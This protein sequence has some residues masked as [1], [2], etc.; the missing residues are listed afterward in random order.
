ML[1]MNTGKYNCQYTI[2]RYSQLSS[3]FSLYIHFDRYFCIWQWVCLSVD[4]TCSFP[5]LYLSEPYCFTAFTQ[6][7]AGFRTAWQA[8]FPSFTSCLT[9]NYIIWTLNTLMYRQHYFAHSSCQFFR[10][11]VTCRFKFLKFVLPFR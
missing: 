8:S 9:K 11:S 5:W 1:L 3:S 7:T 6:S 4:S 2:Y 10:L